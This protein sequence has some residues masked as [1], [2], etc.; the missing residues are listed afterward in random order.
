MLFRSL[1]YFYDLD[2]VYVKA[3]KLYRKLDIE[4]M[5]GQ[6]ALTDIVDSKS[7]EALVKAGRRITRAIVKKIKDLNITEL[8]VQPEDLDGKVLAKPL[9]DES[10]GEIIADANAELNNAIIRR[11]IDSGIDRFFMIFFDGLT[12][13]PY[14]RNTLLVD[15]VTNKEESL[16]EIYKRLRP[17][18]PPTLEAATTFFGR[19]FFDPE[20]YDLSEVGRIKINHRFGI[21]M[22]ECPPS[23]RTLTHKDILSTIKTLIDL[24]NGRGVI[25]DI[26]HLGNRRV[27]SVGEL[28]ENQYRIGLV[29]MERAIRERM[30]LQEI[31]RAHV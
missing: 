5:S 25:D 19:L 17:G 27:R 6:R 16:V 13:G 8:E 10:T 21:S 7:G 1:E 3:G 2:E 9:I 18:E 28:L 29:R 31:G 15:K 20:T 11:A 24:K 22:D 12:V 14:L 4:R 26:D 30:S 23:H